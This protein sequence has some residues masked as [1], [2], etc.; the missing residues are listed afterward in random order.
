M[1]ASHCPQD[2]VFTTGSVSLDYGELTAHPDDDAPAAA[3]IR[4]QPEAV[5]ACMGLAIHQV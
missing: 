2:E 5:L 3:D 4:E 1:L